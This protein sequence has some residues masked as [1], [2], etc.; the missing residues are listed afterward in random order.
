LKY[1]WF[2]ILVV[3]KGNEYGEKH[4]GENSSGHPMKRR[5]WSGAHVAV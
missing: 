1:E 4:G 5:W 2:L 3:E